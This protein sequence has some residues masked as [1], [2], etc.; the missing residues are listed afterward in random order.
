M[1][2]FEFK[3]KKN[4]SLFLLALF[5][6]GTLFAFFEEIYNIK[7]S[8]RSIATSASISIEDPIAGIITNQTNVLYPKNII[9][10]FYSTM[11]ENL[12]NSSLSFVYKIPEN[13]VLFKKTKISNFG[14]SVFYN[15][16]EFNDSTQLEF[17]DINQNG[18]KDADEEVLYDKDK[19][20]KASN[21]N[22][23]LC[24]ATVR[25]FK[26]LLLGVGIKYLYSKIINY[27]VSSITLDTA[28]KI[29]LND[30]FKIS[31]KVNN[32]LSTPS[33]WTTG[34]KENY[35]LSFEAGAVY[36]YKINPSLFL[37]TNLDYGTIDNG[38][39]SIGEEIRYNKRYS[40]RFGFSKSSFNK[41]PNDSFSTGFG[42]ILE[43]GFSIDY[44]LK[45]LKGLQEN[46]HFVSLSYNF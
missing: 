11:L 40:L 5:F 7:G 27:T 41:I 3:I 28:V 26:G 32:L 20:L 14:I 12:S 10:F 13:T 44:A 6:N 18:I 42:V 1:K 30:N 35:S 22:L 9:S 15:N 17:N 45:I 38:Y 2:E 43:N 31:C 19:L 21:T 16:I 24:L 34:N 37:N 36:S 8:A 29:Y 33:S 39:F 4:F 23:A 25:S 46:M